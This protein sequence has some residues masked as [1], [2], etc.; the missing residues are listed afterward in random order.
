MQYNNK[1]KFNN[2]MEIFY[3]IIKLNIDNINDIVYIII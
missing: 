2:I 3:M 1:N